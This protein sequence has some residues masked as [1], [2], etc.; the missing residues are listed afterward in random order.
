LVRL[1]I[2]KTTTTTKK[3]NSPINPEYPQFG[4]WEWH[5]MAE[6]SWPVD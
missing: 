2:A 6:I 4:I 5:K 3:F 1:S